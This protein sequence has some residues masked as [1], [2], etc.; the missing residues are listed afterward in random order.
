[1]T[2]T[3]D[4]RHTDAQLDHVIERWIQGGTLM[5]EHD[6]GRR[7]LLVSGARFFR[8][9]DGW[10][11]ETPMQCVPVTVPATIAALEARIAPLAVAA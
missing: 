9:G 3:P 4:H 10:Q 5:I 7:V 11:F 2:T 1:M 6:T 8:M